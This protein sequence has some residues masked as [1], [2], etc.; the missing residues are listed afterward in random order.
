[1]GPN[2]RAQ[3]REA[4]AARAT[5]EATRAHA[6]R[7]AIADAQKTVA[8]WNARQAGGRDVCPKLA[9]ATKLAKPD[10]QAVPLGH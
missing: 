10:G 9:R 6:D 4:A 8:I 7:K 2:R 1:M 5:Q 3:E